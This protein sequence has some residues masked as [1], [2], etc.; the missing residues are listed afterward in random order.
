MSSLEQHLNPLCARNNMYRS[1][2]TEVLIISLPAQF[3]WIPEFKATGFQGIYQGQK[4]PWAT[5][6]RTALQSH[7][8]F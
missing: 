5:V 1:R 7:H 2:H 8:K 6:V 3:P 4:F